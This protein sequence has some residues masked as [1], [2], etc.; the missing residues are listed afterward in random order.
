[1]ILNKDFPQPEKTDPDAPEILKIVISDQGSQNP[2]FSEIIPQKHFRTGSVGYN[3]SGKLTN[4]IN[5]ERYQVSIN[6]TL[7]GSKPKD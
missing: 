2:L 3:C 7:I 5:G 1:M 4:P 6:I